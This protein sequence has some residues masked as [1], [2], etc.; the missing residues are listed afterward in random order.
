MAEFPRRYS[1]HFADR[2]LRGLAQARVETHHVYGGW[3]PSR[4]HERPDLVLADLH[5]AT[6]RH[7]R[8][9]RPDLSLPWHRVAVHE[10]HGRARDK[11]RIE[12]RRPDEPGLLL[13]STRCP[14]NVGPNPKSGQSVSAGTGGAGAEPPSSFSPRGRS[15]RMEEDIATEGRPAPPLAHSRMDGIRRNRWAS[16]I[17]MG[18][19]RAV[20]S[21]N[22][23]VGLQQGS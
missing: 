10:G 19:R 21:A 1:I 6:R 11:H 3:G 2:H 23:A 4:A 18:G 22:W 13:R 8:G 20:E 5:G 12:Q 9:G 16:S 14:K 15:A 17:G 7:L